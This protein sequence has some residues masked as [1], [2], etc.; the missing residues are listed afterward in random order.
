MGKRKKLNPI[1]EYFEYSESTDKSKCNIC[2]PDI[3]LTGNHVSNLKNHLQSKHP[4]ILKLY[5]AK[6]QKENTAVTLKMDIKFFSILKR[7]QHQYHSI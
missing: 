3:F 2:N 5:A 6:K 1:F 4:D 7:K